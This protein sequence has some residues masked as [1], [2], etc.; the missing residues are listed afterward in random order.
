MGGGPDLTSVTDVSTSR[1]W[2]STFDSRHNLT[3]TRTPLET[4]TDPLVKWQYF[5]HG[6]TKV[7][8]EFHRT[9]NAMPGCDSGSDGTLR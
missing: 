5:P 7:R 1:T 6:V 8:L 2:T 4:G 3:S 9:G